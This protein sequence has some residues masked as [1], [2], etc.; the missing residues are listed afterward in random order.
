MPNHINIPNGEAV[1]PTFS[2]QEMQSRVDKL[3]TLMSAL[4]IDSCLMTSI[5]NI[6]YYSDFLYCS[7][8]RIYGLVINHDTQTTVTANIDGGQPY[9]RTFGENLVYTDWQNDNFYKAAASLINGKQRVGIEFDQVPLEMLE[10][11]KLTM[12]ACEFVDISAGAMKLRMIKSA[13]EIAHITKMTAI[14]D[15]GGAACVEAIGVGVPEHEVALHS[16][17]TM[18]REIAKV[19][20][21]GELLDSWTWFQSGM[22]TDGAHNPVTTKKIES[23]DI[24]SLNCFPMVAGY[25]VA[26]E[27]T[28]FAE[29]A[30]DEHLRMWEVNCKVHDEG[31]KLIVPGARCCDIAY[32]LNEIYAEH[33]LLQYRTFGYGHSFGVLC[34]YYGREAGLE[35]REEVETVLEKD[36]VVSMEPMIMLPEGMPGAGG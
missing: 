12:P 11:F 26:L 4:N 6:N 1:N 30:S 23:G 7:F 18:V 36:M 15:I 19:F 20:P 29:S 31:K 33:D 24:L 21:D 8:G 22:N 28:L 17:Q 35:L 16:T 2:K 5:H 10:K 9:R 27:R 13:E 34:H 32:A 3:R 25:Y 14:A